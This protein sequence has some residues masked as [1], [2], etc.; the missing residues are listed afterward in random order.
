MRSLF[1]VKI[2]WGIF[3]GIGILIIIFLPGVSLL[4]FVALMIAVH[5]FMLVFYAYGYVIPVRY[6]CGALMC[7]Q[8]FVGPAFAYSGLDQFQYFKYR[9]QIPEYDYFMYAIPAVTGFIFGLHSSGQLRGERIDEKCVQVFLKKNADLPYY[10]IGIGFI[11]SIVSPFFGSGLANV[12]YLLGSFKFIGAFILL[13]GGSKLKT[14]PLLLVFGSIVISSLSSA[15]F[16][17][18][19]TWMVFFLAVLAIKYKP[20]ITIKAASAVGLILL[21]IIIQQLKGVYREATQFQGKEGSIEEFDDAYQDAQNQGTLFNKAS[22]ARSNVR[23]NQGFIV[24]YVMKNVPANEPYAKGEEL[25]KILEA[26]FLP[27][28]LAPNKL[29]AGDNQLFTKYSGIQLRQFTSMSL[30]SLGDAYI[31]FGPFFG[32][33]FMFVLG[34]SFNVVLNGFQKF[35]KNFPVILI[36]TPMVFYFPMRP[37]TALQTGLGHLVKASFLLYIMLLFWGKNLEKKKPKISLSSNVQH[38]FTF[39]D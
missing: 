31:N 20:S 33:F 17:D 11:S 1:S 30:S 9:M 35:S 23:I 27:R 26:A 28:I 4:S 18:L 7:L 25:Y 12:F 29:Q 32:C 37:D 39:P 14:L 6:W 21:V 22:L 15:M 3:F 2:N 34:W 10:F 16:H 19:I 13:L 36:F 8:M 24:T 5:Q 38:V